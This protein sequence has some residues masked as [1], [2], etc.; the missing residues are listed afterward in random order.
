MVDQPPTLSAGE[1]P[2]GGTASPRRTADPNRVIEKLTNQ[3][4]GLTRELAVSHSIL[5]ELDEENVELRSAVEQLQAT[6]VTATAGQAATA[7][8]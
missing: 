5:E 4:A 7:D 3:V 8:A 2:A 6:L 1:Q